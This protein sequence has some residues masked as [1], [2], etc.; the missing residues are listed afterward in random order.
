MPL[1]NRHQRR[2]PLSVFVRR[3]S[4]TITTTLAVVAAVCVG[5]LIIVLE[6]P[7]ALFDIP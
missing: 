3:A 5:L 2:Q 4:R 6:A 1:V 7:S